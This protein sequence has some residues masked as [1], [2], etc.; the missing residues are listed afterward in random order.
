MGL[1]SSLSS[2]EA[3]LY[4]ASKVMMFLSDTLENIAILN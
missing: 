3:I 2:L 4:I 1:L